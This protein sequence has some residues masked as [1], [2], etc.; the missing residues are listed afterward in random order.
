MSRLFTS[1]RRS[2]PAAIGLTIALC[3]PI[4]LAADPPPAKGKPVAAS[5]KPREGSF[6]KGSSTLPLLTRDE[7]RHNPGRWH[8]PPVRTAGHA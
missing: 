7:L 5:P 8:P 3:A 2:A 4:A 6:G 1:W